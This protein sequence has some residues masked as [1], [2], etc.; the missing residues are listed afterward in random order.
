[1]R[2]EAQRGQEVAEML[3]SVAPDAIHGFD[4]SF[5]AWCLGPSHLVREA[6]EEAATAW[7]AATAPRAPI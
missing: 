2:V 7:K 5:I 6:H 3:P 1:M 4:E